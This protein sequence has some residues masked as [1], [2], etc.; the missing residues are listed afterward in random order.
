MYET[1]IQR[2]ETTFHMDFAIAEHFG[3]DAICDTFRRAH[4]GWKNSVQYFTPSL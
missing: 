3:E 1:E 2:P 4:V